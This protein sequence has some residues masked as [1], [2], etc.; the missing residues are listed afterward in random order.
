MNRSWPIWRSMLFVP[1]HVEKFVAAAHTRGADAYILDLEDSVPAAEKAAARESIA[2]SAA[3]VSQSGAAVLAR[4][5][6]DK[7]LLGDD[8]Q[9]SVIP[10]I[11]A[12]ML[13]KIGSGDDMRAIDAQIGELEARRSLPPG[14]TLLI[15]QIEHVR[16]LPRLDEIAASSTRLMGMILGSEDFSVSAGMEPTLEALYGP[17]QQ[18]LFACRRAGILPFGFPGSIGVFRDLEQL[19]LLIRR[20]REMGFVG[21]YAIHPNQ[22]TVMNELFLPAAEEVDHA[23]ELLAGWDTALAQGRGAFEFRG[24]MVD[25]PVVARA[26]EVLRRFAAAARS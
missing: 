14:H 8:L 22:V 3:L 18:M 9:A 2:R 21:S 10:G 17:N 5:N 15:A 7:A 6:G 4:I 25:P 1:A 20:A 11:S 12:L 24:R 26:Q 23:R 19:R 16:T 13:P